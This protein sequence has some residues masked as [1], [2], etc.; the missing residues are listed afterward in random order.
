M[1]DK[2]YAFH[3]LMKIRCLQITLQC[4]EIMCTFLSLRVVLV[5]N[6]VAF[7][8]PLSLLPRVIIICSLPLPDGDVGIFRKAFK[9]RRRKQAIQSL[10]CMARHV[11]YTSA[12]FCPTFPCQSSFGCGVARPLRGRQLSHHDARRPLFNDRIV[13]SIISF[14][15]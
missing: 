11:V 9:A 13:I 7:F 10:F 14:I 4:G 15:C 1:T 2:K 5:M 3:I 8:F 12:P 6:N